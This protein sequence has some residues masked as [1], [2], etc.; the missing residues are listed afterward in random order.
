MRR[1]ADHYVG[2]LLKLVK[3]LE[4]RAAPDESDSS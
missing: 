2:A 1:V 3:A 4:A